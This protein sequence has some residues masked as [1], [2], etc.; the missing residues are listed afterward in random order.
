MS[1]K[2]IAAI[3]MSKLENVVGG[4]FKQGVAERA[5]GQAEINR[6]LTAAGQAASAARSAQY[7]QPLGQD[8]AAGQGFGARVG[9]WI[10]E[11]V[12]A[13]PGFVHGIFT[14]GRAYDSTLSTELNK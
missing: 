11:K 12:A 5:A 1:T 7:H 2:N 6:S 9:G 10:G 13:V 8:T 14:G 3:E 4:T